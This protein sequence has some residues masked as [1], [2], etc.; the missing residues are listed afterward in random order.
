M[1]VHTKVSLTNEMGQMVPSE[2]SSQPAILVNQTSH[3][4]TVKAMLVS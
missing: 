1:C 3:T 4:F 2:A